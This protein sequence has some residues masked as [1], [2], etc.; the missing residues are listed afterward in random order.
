[1]GRMNC[2]RAEDIFPSCTES[3]WFLNALPQSWLCSIVVQSVR[4]GRIR[5]HDQW[6][7]REGGGWEMNFGQFLIEF[8]RVFCT[9]TCR[10]DDIQQWKRR[11]AG[12][13]CVPRGISGVFY[14]DNLLTTG[15][16]WRG[17]SEISSGILNWYFAQCTVQYIAFI[18]GIFISLCRVECVYES[19]S[20]CTN[21]LLVVEIIRAIFL[22]NF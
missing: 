11:V 13:F 2:P 16:Q 5:L 12:E 4:V 20:S 21:F 14:S 15:L 1:M 8:S 6:Q 19:L 7:T 9:R 10:T 18:R 22:L 3:E 17:R